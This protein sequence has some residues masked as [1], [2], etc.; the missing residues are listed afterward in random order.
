MGID[1]GEEDRP[2][3]NVMEGLEASSALCWV[4]VRR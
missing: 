2:R 3:V 4:S 1:D